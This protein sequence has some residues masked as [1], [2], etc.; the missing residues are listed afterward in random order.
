MERDDLLL[1]LLCA[2]ATVEREGCIET[3][4]ALGN[5]YLD[6]EACKVKPSSDPIITEIQFSVGT[7]SHT[8][9]VQ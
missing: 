1:R 5:M 2:L 7:M 3:I 4:V 6:L 8:L 9:T